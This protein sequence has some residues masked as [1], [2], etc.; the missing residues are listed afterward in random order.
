MKGSNIRSPDMMAISG[1]HPAQSGR[2]VHVIQM[3]WTGLKAGRN[4]RDAHFPHIPLK[5]FPIHGV[6]VGH[7]GGGT[8][9][10]TIERR[11][12]V[13]RVNALFYRH[14]LGIRPDGPVIEARPVET[15]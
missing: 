3:G 8:A 7:Q 6:A 4:A 5:P 14:C 2:I 9:S 10:R 13:D 1:G 15:D 11:I 12:R